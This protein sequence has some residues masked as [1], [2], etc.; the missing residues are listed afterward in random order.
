MLWRKT[1]ERIPKFVETVD[2]LVMRSDSA[3]HRK[4]LC[5]VCIILRALDLV[6]V[7]T[8]AIVGF[9]LFV[10]LKKMAEGFVKKLHV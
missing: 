9:D 4:V 7:P 2:G 5:W 1:W 8:V 10:G 6:G 3:L